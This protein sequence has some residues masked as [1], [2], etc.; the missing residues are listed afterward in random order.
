MATTSAQRGAQRLLRVLSP[1]QVDSMRRLAADR[2]T[3]VTCDRI[4]GQVRDDGERALRR[5]A[6]ELGDLDAG[7]A[8]TRSPG[9]LAAAAERIAPVQRALLERTAERIESFARAQREAF[10]DLC[11]AVPGGEAGHTVAPVEHAGCY[12]PGG[13]F[14]LPSSVL[15]TAVPARVAGVES[16]WVA[17][18]RPNDTTLAAAHI[19]GADGVLAVGGAQAI[20]ALAYG[21]EPLPR[22]DV[23]VGPGNRWVTAAK[24][25]VAGVVGIDMLA[26]PSELVVLADERADPEL[27]AA[28]LLAQAEHDTDALPVLVTTSSAFVDR[29]EE[30]LARQ[31]ADLPTAEIAAV[32]LKNGFAV[33]VGTIEEA[34]R[35]CDRLAPEHLQ[36][37]TE[38]APAAALLC[39]Q[40]GALFIGS[41]SAEVLG[42]YGAGP[43]HT[44]PTSGTARFAGGLSV[45][46]F[47]RV[48]TWL[49]IDD[50]RAASGLVADAEALAAAEGLVGHQRA[51]ARRRRDRDPTF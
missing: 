15:M 8:L 21:V 2:D 38:D 49:R 7:A 34:A 20:A 25:L 10:S 17:S 32:A 43:N 1:D 6:Q 5:W 26:G 37:M 9:E 13:R 33:T 47:M 29:V 45:L 31:L 28:D 48:R 36:V 46:D 44:L 16:V 51:A 42:D 14:G 24:Q 4:V 3:L 41:Q 11:V 27:V 12:A 18:P 39:S 22:C 23:I 19:A 35:L 50:A 30:A 40:Y